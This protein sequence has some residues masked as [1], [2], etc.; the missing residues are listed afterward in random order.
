MIKIAIWW[1][2]YTFCE[3]TSD[4]MGLDVCWFVLSDFFRGSER[5]EIPRRII[6]EPHCKA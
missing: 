2:E 6:S 4:S 3:S 5:G 1:W